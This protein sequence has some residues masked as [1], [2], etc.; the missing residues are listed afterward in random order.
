MASTSF[1]QRWLSEVEAVGTLI[2][3]KSQIKFLLAELKKYI[4]M[5]SDFKESWTKATNSVK[6]DRAI[7][8]A[9]DK[10]DQNKNKKNE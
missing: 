8:N 10:K 1:C 3:C 2:N 9:K 7:A 5:G 6:N 4:P